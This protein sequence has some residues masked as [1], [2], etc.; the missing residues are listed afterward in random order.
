MYQY[1]QAATESS[2]LDNEH[3]KKKKMKRWNVNCTRW[4]VAPLGHGNFIIP[5]RHRILWCAVNYRDENDFPL[6]WYD[7]MGEPRWAGWL[8]LRIF[9]MFYC[10]DYKLFWAFIKLPRDTLLGNVSQPQT[11]NHVQLFERKTVGIYIGPFFCSGAWLASCLLCFSL[12]T[13][14]RYISVSSSSTPAVKNV[15][16]AP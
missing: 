2:G 15:Q 11:Q 9:E 5:E 13:N 6:C 14:P 8:I 3:R 12:K 4:K 1:R 16:T 7:T 10:S